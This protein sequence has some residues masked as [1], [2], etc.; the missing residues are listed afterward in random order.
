M[1]ARG[2]LAERAALSGQD[3][4]LLS[5]QF[6]LRKG[7]PPMMCL[8]DRDLRLMALLLDVNYLLTSQL[9]MLGW[10]ASRTR[11][12]QR[13]LKLLHDGGFLD[14][15]RSVCRVGSAEWIYRLS[16]RGWKVLASQEMVN[17]SAR[18]KPAG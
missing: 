7:A 6:G 17:P 14:R 5:V 9:V 8:T 1:S 13:R 2:S 3:V 12:A 11:A 15:F 18:Y 16:R 4:G 10:G